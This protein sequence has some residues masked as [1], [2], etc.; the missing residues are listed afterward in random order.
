M[1]TLG[2]NTCKILI[3]KVTDKIA[4]K[5]FYI[6]VL[7]ALPLSSPLLLHKGSLLSIL[8]KS[9][10]LHQVVHQVCNQ[11]QLSQYRYSSCDNW[12]K[13]TKLRTAMCWK[14]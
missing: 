8:T 7:S 13:S 6:T 3:L 5:C 4:V 11:F 14:V 10:I 9:C 1:K 12:M 2:I